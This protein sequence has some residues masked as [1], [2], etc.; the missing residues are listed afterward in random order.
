MTVTA[1]QFSRNQEYYPGKDRF[2][3]FGPFYQ[4]ECQW[5]NELSDCYDTKREA[6]A[7]TLAHE[8]RVTVTYHQMEES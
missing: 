3:V 8:C 4:A 5:C 1:D 7:W 2:E 6:Q